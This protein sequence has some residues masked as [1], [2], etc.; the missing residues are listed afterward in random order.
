MEET[1]RVCFLGRE[2]LSKL[3]LSLLERVALILSVA[4]NLFVLY[5]LFGDWRTN[6]EHV[7][8]NVVLNR[9]LTLEGLKDIRQELSQIKI[10]LE[11]AYADRTAI[12]DIIE[13]KGVK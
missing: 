10:Q 4:G 7:K 5:A 6:P 2:P 8:Q 1:N 13:S 12:K 9:Q 11:V 3:R